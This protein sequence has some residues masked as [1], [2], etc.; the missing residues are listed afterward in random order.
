MRHPRL[1]EMRHRLAKLTALAEESRKNGKD[2]QAVR[3]FYSL[4]K[5]EITYREALAK[6]GNLAKQE[7]AQPRPP[8]VQRTQLCN[9]EALQ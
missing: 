8:G 5:G 4:G 1:L 9:P 2:R 3:I 6:L 7:I